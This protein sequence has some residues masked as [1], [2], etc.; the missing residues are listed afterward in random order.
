MA[1]L[2]IEDPLHRWPAAVWRSPDTNTFPATTSERSSW[3][4][5]VPKPFFHCQEER[6]V[7]DDRLTILCVVH[8]LRLDV[9]LPNTRSCF[10]SVVPPPTISGDLLM[11]LFAS[12]SKSDS[13][14]HAMRPDVTFIVGQTKIRAHKLVLAVRSPVFAA[15]FRWHMNESIIIRVDDDD[16]SASTFRA[17]LR[18]IYTDEL[19]IKPNNDRMILTS[20][21][22]HAARLYEAMV[23]DLLVA[24]DRYDLQRLRLLGEKVLAEGMDDKSVI[25]TLMVV[26]GRYS[27][28]QLEDLCIEYIASHPNVYSDLKAT[29]EYNEIKNSC[30]S[31]LLEVTDKVDMIDMAPKASSSNLQS[32]KRKRNDGG[33]VVVHGS[34]KF[35]I[36]YFRA[37]QRSLLAVGKNTICSGIFQ[38]GGYNWQLCVRWLYPS[39]SSEF[40]VY[41]CV[42]SSFETS[43]VTTSIGFKID[44][45]SGMSLPPITMVEEI[46]TEAEYFRHAK[47]TLM[48]STNSSHDDSLTIHCHLNV[49]KE[50]ACTSSSTISDGAGVTVVV[51]PP[52]I[53]LHLEQ[54]LLGGQRSDV[55][56]LVEECD[57]RAHGL[58]IAARS[59]VL[60]Q[61]VEAAAAK[62]DN[63]HIVR[64]DDMKAAVFRSVLHFIYTDKLPSIDNPV[65]A[66]EDML[67]AAC[68]F[69]LERLKIACENFFADHISNKNA[70]CTL[71][72][73]Q[74]HHCL[75]LE[76]Y[77]VKFIST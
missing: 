17:M 11:L 56:F 63:H 74:R 77:C 5:S 18:F 70:L 43:H 54:L 75:E 61:V 2:R 3:K 37:V 45:P 21:D 10:I 19:P 62:V 1:S 6:Y 40:V 29:E 39:N 32:H 34:H 15:E 7:V 24:A 27:C 72:L 12:M 44:D 13:V 58:V 59:P 8:V 36:P 67:A 9:T 55:R 42:V 20:E 41:L 51:P 28:R 60:Y 71:K 49:T 31:F 35:T 52:Y 30:F 16:M 33:Q 4:L 26:H 14:K 73:A 50:A 23:R 64:V 48:K 69:G 66:V 38:V 76:K 25:P 57:I 47:F 68:R 53:G 65:L 46:F 22:K